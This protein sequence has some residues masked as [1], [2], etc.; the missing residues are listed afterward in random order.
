MDLIL[1]VTSKQRSIRFV[2]TQLD[3]RG[4]QRTGGRL[5]YKGSHM[6]N[7]LGSIQTHVLHPQQIR[8][9]AA[10]CVYGMRVPIATVGHR[11]TQIH[12]EIGLAR[13]QINT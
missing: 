6:H 11:Q 8:S 1:R 2:G 13:R 4:F 9:I 12:D 7:D 10:K 3:A 5:R